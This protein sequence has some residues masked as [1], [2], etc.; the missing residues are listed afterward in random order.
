MVCSLCKKITNT[1][2]Y[3]NGYDLC[4]ECYAVWKGNYHVCKICGKLEPAEYF[5]EIREILRKKQICFECWHWL[6]L[7][8]K[9]NDPRSIRIKH[10]HY[11]VGDGKG[12]FKGF[13]GRYFKIKLFNGKIIETNDLWYQGEIPERFWKDLS[14][15][16]ELINL[17][18]SL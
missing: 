14:D 8:K 10:H 17:K 6:G 15:N 4:E 2:F 12:S 13:G 9:K 16:A 11:W 5:P 1:T 7:I 3:V 18:G